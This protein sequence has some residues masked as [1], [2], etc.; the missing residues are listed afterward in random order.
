MNT[1][2]PPQ[3]LAILAN[4]LVLG[5]LSLSL[6]GGGS[7]SGLSVS[8]DRAAY[9]RY[10]LVRLAAKPDSASGLDSSAVVSARFY[11]A[12]T[13]VAGPGQMDSVALKWDPVARSWRGTWT[14]PWNP[15]LGRY[16]AIVSA[17]LA[18]SQTTQDSAFFSL[19]ARQPK[20]I[21]DG[22]CVMTIESAG[23]MLNAKIPSLSGKPKGW[24]NFAEWAKFLGADAV[25]YSV[26]WTIEGTR[27]I[28]DQSPWIKDNF[29]VF[30]K[31]AEECH[32][33]GLKF[34]AYVGSYLLWGPYLR[35]LKYNYSL[36]SSRGRVYRNHHVDLDDPKRRADIVSVIKM[37]EEDPNVD[38][39]GLDYIRP[40]AGG[41]ES[42]DSFVVSMNIET[43]SHWQK[44]DQRQR[45]L[46]VAQRVRP[47]SY[48]PIHL[49]WQWWQAHRS[50]ITVEKLLAEAKVTKPVWGF[51]LGWDKGHEHG[52]DPMMMNDAGLD[53]DAVM[54]YESNAWHCFNMTN[55]WSKYLTGH[56]AQIIAGQQVDWDLLQKSTAP[57]APE[58]MYIRHTDAIRGLSSR[59]PIKGLFWHDLFRGLRGRKG[60]HSSLEWLIVGAAAFTKVRQELGLMPLSARLTDESG[61]LRLKVSCN[62]PLTGLKIESLTPRSPLSIREVDSLSSDTLFTLG[63]T[64]T[65]GLVAYRLRWGDGPRE[66]YVIFSYFPRTYGTQPFRRLQSF[67]AGGDALIVNSTG[68]M[69]YA[70]ADSLGRY[71][72]SIGM[73]VNRAP[74]DSLESGIENKYNWLI[75]LGKDSLA[76]DLI[77]T[78]G[79]RLVQYSFRRT[80]E[81]PCHLGVIYPDGTNDLAEIIGKKGQTIERHP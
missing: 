79:G 9:L 30:P 20:K 27:G 32:A 15:P 63:K 72:R 10:Q 65:K 49:R 21:D 26:G 16:K 25:W 47:L 48:T 44:M 66:T 73:T 3:R 46:W 11:H 53:L 5:L 42:V 57:P 80:Y 74:L 2:A 64:P 67:R 7:G 19:T 23:N 12:D 51:T 77:K 28:S 59:Y 70:V 76:C 61:R 13:L 33:Q 41:F 58:E 4:A 75:L 1:V 8:T 43:P 69:G 56:E 40:G 55:Q 22:F 37:L 71:L 18:D 81:P 17:S 78:W 62:K 29:K 54:L 6:N 45:I 68:I 52:Q 60:P 24:R 14:P 50:A 39:I 36:E 35:K 38:F 31:L 34:G